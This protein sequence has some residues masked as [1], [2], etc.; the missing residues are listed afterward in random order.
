MDF[1]IDD[2][3]REDAPLIVDAI[4]EAV[5]DD[6]TNHLAG[7]KHTVKTVHDLFQG[8]AE[9]EDTQ[10]SFRNTR[11]AR[12]AEGLPAGVCISYDGADLKKLRRPFFHEANATMGWEMTDEEIEA[13]PGETEPDEFYLDT[14][15]VLP[16][17]RGK[18]VAKA[19]IADAKRKAAKTGKPLSL[20]CDLDNH[21]AHT[22]Y[23]SVGFKDVGH[24]PFAGHIMHHMQTG[25]K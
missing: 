5:G 3:V 20:L 11:I 10:Y 21:R 12:T 2:A 23:E 13:L 24:R 7:E 1:I 8:L 9:R 19:L 4:L 16:E 6:I 17:F 18:G 14:I 15:M 25:G 22:L